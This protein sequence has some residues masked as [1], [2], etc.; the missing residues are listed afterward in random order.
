MFNNIENLR[1]F[2]K[3][4]K[5][6]TCLCL[7]ACINLNNIYDVNAQSS[8][9]N[10]NRKSG[11]CV[12]IYQ[13]NSLLSVIQKFPISPQEL[14]FLR[15]SQCTDGHGN[16]PYV[17]CTADKNYSQPPTT[18]ATIVEQ[19]TPTVAVTK[20]ASPSNGMG[21]VLPEP[22]RCGP[23]PLDGKIYNGIDT[24]I[25]QYP[26]MVLLEY[27]NSKDGQ[28]VLN[29]GGSLINQRYVLT[30]AH[31]VKGE[32]E[33]AV[34]PLTRIRLGEYDISSEIDCIG[35]DC[36]NKVLELGFE[37]I[38][39]HPQY[40]DKNSNRYHDIALIRLDQDVE[41]N[42]FI[43]PVCLPVAATKQD[44]NTGA[45]LTVAGWG[46]TLLAR[47]SNV[48][49]QLDIPVND[50]NACVQKFATRKINIGPTQLCAG[51][52]FAKDSC[53]GDSGGPLMRKA[54]MKRWYLEGIVS[55][56][57][58]CGLEGWPGVY[59]RVSEYTDW[60]QSSLKP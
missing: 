6:L 26:W 46:R 45:L 31:C 23:D 52:E 7:I 24:A 54:F 38:I 56:G 21:N 35:S 32:I 41:Y 12:S 14:Q 40:D 47:Q 18:T 17:C 15:E 43:R 42:D 49:K 9:S 8:C 5:C 51:G 34:G 1:Q 22:P 11:L 10:P 57:N 25:D 2:L 37:E 16:P 27:R 55:F 36:N 29:C 60:I 39:P 3:N 13:C 44:I 33:T 19:T 30:A 53:D 59:T 4:V 28:P 58:R 50:H 20:N 48:K